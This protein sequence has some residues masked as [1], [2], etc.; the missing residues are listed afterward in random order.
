M[1]SPDRGHHRTATRLAQARASFCRN[2]P[3]L[4]VSTGERLRQTVG[5]PDDDTLA[6]A[7]RDFL[8]ALVLELRPPTSVRERLFA[9]IDRLPHDALL[10]PEPRTAPA[11]DP[12][13]AAA[14]CHGLCEPFAQRSSMTKRH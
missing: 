9:W 6:D 12:A 7:A 8:R 10:P 1:R 3:D 11:P 5:V 13:K 4:R 2:A 14:T